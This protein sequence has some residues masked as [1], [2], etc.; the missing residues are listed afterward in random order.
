MKTT[1]S[2]FELIIRENCAIKSRQWWLK[3]WEKFNEL[4]IKHLPKS[5]IKLVKKSTLTVLITNNNEIKNL[6]YKYRKINKPTDVLSFHL[7]KKEQIKNRYLGDVVISYEKAKKQA[8]EKHLSTESE[9]LMLL[10]HGC[11]HLLDYNHQL[12]KNKK[13]MFSLQNKILKDLVNKE[14]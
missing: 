7:N 12:K 14:G 2:N 10:I 6:N 13:I 9:L 8:Y 5:K 3:R 1:I 4:L 11:L